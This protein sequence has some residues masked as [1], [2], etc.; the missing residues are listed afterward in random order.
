MV[1]VGLLAMAG[2]IGGTLRRAAPVGEAAAVVK[3]FRRLAS[4]KCSPNSVIHATL[5]QH[6]RF[7]W[8]IHNHPRRAG[9]PAAAGL[10]YDNGGC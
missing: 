7:V 9:R 2:G 4:F 5:R 3:A 10:P 1:P 8:H 6:L